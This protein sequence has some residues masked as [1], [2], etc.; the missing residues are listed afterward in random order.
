MVDAVGSL[1]HCAVPGG[2]VLQW[3]WTCDDASVALDPTSRTTSRLHILPYTFAAGDSVTMTVSVRLSDNG[4]GS[5]T[6]ASTQTIVVQ[7]QGSPE[8]FA[9]IVGGSSLLVYP[10]APLVLD[11][12]SSYG[13]DDPLVSFAT[14]YPYSASTMFLELI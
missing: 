7:T 5:P 9:A 2:A 14:K 3:H 1:S 8:V 12:S 6:P 10:G 13:P 11:G 4:S